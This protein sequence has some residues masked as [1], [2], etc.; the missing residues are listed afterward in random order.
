MHFVRNNSFYIIDKPS[1]PEEIKV[2]DVF[3][4]HCKLSWKPPA[5]DGGGEITEYIVE[6]QE[7]GTGF[8]EKVPVI[9]SGNTCQVKD[10]TPGKKYNFR[11][12]AANVYGVSDPCQTDKPTLAKNP[13]GKI[14]VFTLLLPL[15]K[16]TNIWPR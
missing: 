13:F 6:K 15:C 12:K 2:E 3:A 9:G 7:E 16:T 1:P 4:E 5:D 14:Y 11:V 8:W 10:L